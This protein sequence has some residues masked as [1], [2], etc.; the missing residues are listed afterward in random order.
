MGRL[1]TANLNDLLRRWT[2]NGSRVPHLAN[3]VSSRLERWNVI[4]SY[5]DVAI[6]NLCL[7][8][9]IIG[10]NDGSRPSSGPFLA[11]LLLVNSRFNGFVVR[12]VCAGISLD[13][14]SKSFVERGLFFLNVELV[15]I[16][17]AK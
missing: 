7:L 2:R 16:K 5:C 4:M 17:D 10:F 11:L 6:S 3:K 8:L 15:I 1:R 14:L 13:L 12:I 9:L